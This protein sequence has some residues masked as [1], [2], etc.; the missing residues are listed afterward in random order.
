MSGPNVTPETFI[1][2]LPGSPGFSSPFDAAPDGQK[3]KFTAQDA[4]YKLRSIRDW[5][6]NEMGI[7]WDSQLG[8]MSTFEPGTFAPRWFAT[9]GI[10]KAGSCAVAPACYMSLSL[11]GDVSSVEFAQVAG[12]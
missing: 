10:K 8:E 1:A 2:G 6:S 9:V 7:E 12:E 3:V 11:G 4:Y 5:L